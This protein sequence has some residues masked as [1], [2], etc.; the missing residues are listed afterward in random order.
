MGREEPPRGESQRA[1]ESTQGDEFPGRAKV[2]QVPELQDP[3][4]GE[5]QGLLCVS[6]IS[7]LNGGSYCVVLPR[8][9]CFTVRVWGWAGQTDC[10]FIDRHK[11]DISLLLME[12]WCVTL[13]WMQRLAGTLKAHGYLAIQGHSNPWPVSPHLSRTDVGAQHHI[14]FATR[15]FHLCIGL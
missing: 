3:T 10:L 9:Q 13:L 8:H 15:G 7:S 6:I 5:D 14:A 12:R 1:T 4:T 11:W 2:S